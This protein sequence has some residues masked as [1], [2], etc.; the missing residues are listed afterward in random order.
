[1]SDGIRINKYLAECGVCSRR[2]AD[3]IIADGR[4]SLN[5]KAAS[6]GERVMPGDEVMLDGKRLKAV[7]RKVVLAYYKPVGVTVSS[8]DPHAEETVAEVI[9]YPLRVTYAGRLDKDSEGLLL[10]SNDGNL[11]NAMMKG[12]AGHEKEYIVH[13][14]REPAAEDIERLS[15]GVWLEDLKRKTRP[16]RIE[17]ISRNAVRIVL[18]EG[19]NR[20]IRRMW[21]LAGYHVKALKRIRVISVSLGDLQPGEYTELDEK[22]MR[23][24]YKAVGLS[25]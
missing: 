6:A 4:V 24:L 25:L 7:E 10:L 3:R 5:G 22:Q 15:K 13:L 17:K 19:L 14:N 2:E 16:C 9:D 23:E 8:R 20:Q 12:R 21:R 11:I 18:T 1:M